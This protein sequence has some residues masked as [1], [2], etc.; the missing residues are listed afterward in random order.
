MSAK[1]WWPLFPLLFV[2]VLAA[3][4]MAIIRYSKSGKGTRKGWIGL[5]MALLF[6]VLTFALGRW[7]WLH[8][9][10]S[11]IAELFMIYNAYTFF[12]A[13]ERYIAWCN[14]IALIAIGIDFALHFI[15]K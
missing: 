1:V 8:M 2:I 7:R 5:G 4:I 14:V 6:Y 13:R 10:L 15:L 9:P 11:N 3:L 12:K